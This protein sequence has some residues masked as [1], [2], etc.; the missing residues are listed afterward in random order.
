MDEYM[1]EINDLHRRIAKLKFENASVVIIEE[2]EAQLRILKAIYDSANAL[3]TAGEKN[4]R[5]Q[6]GFRERELGPWTFE[7]VYFYVYEQAVALEPEDHDLATLIWHHDY[8]G[9]L[10]SPV[11]A[12]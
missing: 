7:N 3:F 1:L 8:A 12:K 9:P 6:A 4:P 11:A 5:L 10:L 2:L